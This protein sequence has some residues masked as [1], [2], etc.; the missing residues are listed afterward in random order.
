M[1]YSHHKSQSSMELLLKYLSPH[2]GQNE[3]IRENIMHPREEEK[4][5]R[6]RKRNK[7][8]TNNLA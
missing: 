7:R 6:E 4:K 8:A 5:K 2:H 1:V 3:L